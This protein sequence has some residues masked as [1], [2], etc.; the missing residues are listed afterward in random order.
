MGR[1]PIKFSMIESVEARCSEGSAVSSMENE[2]KNIVFIL[3]VRQKLTLITTVPWLGEDKSEWG[4]GVDAWLAEVLGQDFRRESHRTFPWAIVNKV[5]TSRELLYFKASAPAGMHEPGLVAALAR[6]WPDITPILRAGNETGWMLQQDHGQALKTFGNV[7]HRLKLWE[8]ILPG[9][10]EIQIASATQDSDLKDLVKTNR[11]MS[12]LPSK[13][14]TCLEGVHPV[15]GIE[16]SGETRATALKT[17]SLLEEVCNSLEAMPLS[18]T[19]DHGDLHDGNLFLANHELRLLDWGDAC[20]THP[21]CSMVM[22]YHA[23]KTWPEYQDSSFVRL[24][25]AYLEPWRKV[26][27]G[28]SL[29][30]LFN[31]AI[32]AAYAGRA[33][34]W[35]HMLTGV[36]GDA[37]MQW[38]GQI[39]VWFQRWLDLSQQWDEI[40]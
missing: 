31:K 28:L 14:R 8:K 40:A 9:Y 21:F 35:Q 20:L 3:C 30:T 27:P 38:R 5:T 10:A 18:T 6:K 25:D 11:S 34:N 12:L 15:S 2:Q 16:M 23:F 37:W 19:L 33:L 13:T 7:K 26:C 29:T 1:Q 4:R 22:L 24:R 32:W 36:G 17:L 39:T